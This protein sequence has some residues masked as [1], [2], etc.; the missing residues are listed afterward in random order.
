MSSKRE[1]QP[2]LSHL[3]ERGAVRMVG[4]GAKPETARRAVAEAEV[5]MSA[6]TM[7]LVAGSAYPEISKKGDVLATARLAG[8]MACKRT[9]ELIPLC[10][11]VR[12]VGTDVAL[13]IDADL[14]GVRVRVTVDAVDRT[15]V[16]MEA[17]VGAS[18]A[19]L[20]IYDMVKGVERG[21]E[22]GGVRLVEKRGGKSGVWRRAVTKPSVDTIK[23]RKFRKG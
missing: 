14:P 13:T 16:E 22:V 18:V 15:G 3:D 17:M 20:T 5:R 12:V 2:G 21:V 11:P 4:V 19:A 23:V 7:A 6:A 8:V 1:G 9:A 10:H